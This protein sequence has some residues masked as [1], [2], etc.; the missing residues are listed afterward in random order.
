MIIFA[1]KHFS[2]KNVRTFSKLINIAIY[3]RASI[4]VFQRII[5]RW[6]LPII[7]LIF[8]NWFIFGI[9]IIYQNITGISFPD[10]TIKYLIPFYAFIWASSNSIFGNQIHPSNTSIYLKEI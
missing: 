6:I 9:S 4:A 10:D 5:K 1:E 7:V 2:K 8:F 3:I